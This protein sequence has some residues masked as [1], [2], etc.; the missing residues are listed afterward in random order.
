MSDLEN[1][2]DFNTPD[3]LK[4]KKDIDEKY[5]H[6]MTMAA[7]YPM[8]YSDSPKATKQKTNS[9]KVSSLILRYRE[10][11]EQLKKKIEKVKKEIAK[12]QE[13]NKF[14]QE[15]LRKKKLKKEFVKSN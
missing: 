14:A 11:N 1:F 2:D 13:K 15:K 6:I 8:E 3:I 9:T 4:L 10:E 5:K 12:E 7:D